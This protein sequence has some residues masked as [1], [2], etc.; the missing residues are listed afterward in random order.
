[1]LGLII[2]RGGGVAVGGV[3]LKVV[4]AIE[5]GTLVSF[6]LLEKLLD[7]LLVKISFQLVLAR[8]VLVLLGQWATKWSGSP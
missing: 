4:E 8:G 6:R 3:F 2:A 7:R 5:D 1:V